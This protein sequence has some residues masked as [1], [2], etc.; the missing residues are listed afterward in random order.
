MLASHLAA[1]SQTLGPHSHA[2]PSVGL[3]GA[4][5]L[6]LAVRA[7]GQLFTLSYQQIIELGGITARPSEP[8]A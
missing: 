3:I 1:C 5:A 8:P 7:G 6:A 2:T 4:A